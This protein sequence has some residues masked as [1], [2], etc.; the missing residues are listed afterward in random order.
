[1]LICF[2]AV[3]QWKIK[4]EGL[5]LRLTVGQGAHCVLLYTRSSSAREKST[6]VDQES[7]DRLCVGNQVLNSQPHS[8]IYSNTTWKKSQQDCYIEGR[9]KETRCVSSQPR[10][11]PCQCVLTDQ[12]VATCK[13]VLPIQ[14][15]EKQKTKSFKILKEDR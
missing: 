12:F 13:V 6:N 8:P 11:G 4:Y 1:M 2:V 15:T 9:Q 5:P 3:N 10:T 7:C 14:S